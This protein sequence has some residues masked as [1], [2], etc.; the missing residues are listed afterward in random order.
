MSIGVVCL[1]VVF[2]QDAGAQQSVPD[3]IGQ[4]AIACSACHGKEGRATSEGYFPRIA[5][6]PAGYLY[7]QLVNFREGY[8]QYPMM[9]YMVDQMSDAYLKELAEYFSSQHPPYPP[10]QSI[11]A[12]KEQL[13]RG[14]Q[15]ALS[16]DPARQVPACVA[17][18]GQKLT[19]VVPAIPG[20][21][22]LPHDY[23]NSQFGA[24]RNKSRRTPAPDCMAEIT[25]RLSPTDVNAVAA[26]LASQP[27]PSDGAPAAS[28]SAKLPLPCGSVSGVQISAGAAQKGNRP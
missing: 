19:G 18:H 6:K 16:G 5:G 26:W 21:L 14:R 22:G 11:S 3:T 25:S 2:N 28:L 7:N 1:A 8:R 23:L 15:L 24:W 27:V 4:R 13:E 17:C 10:P 20:L 12:S 9:T